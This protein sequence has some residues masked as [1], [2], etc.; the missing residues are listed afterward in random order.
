[1]AMVL[2]FCMEYYVP[3]LDDNEQLPKNADN[4]AR[5]KFYFNFR[6]DGY[7]NLIF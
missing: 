3:I 7:L 5:F 4:Q 6:K 2:K 1:M